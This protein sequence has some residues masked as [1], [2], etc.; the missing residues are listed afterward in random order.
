MKANADKKLW[1]AVFFEPA[2][3]ILP[4]SQLISQTFVFKKINTRWL[5]QMK[6]GIYKVL[7]KD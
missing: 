2:A 4:V 6:G 7:S 3:Y 1:K 5:F